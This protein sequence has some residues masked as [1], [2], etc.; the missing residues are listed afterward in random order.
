MFCFNIT[1]VSMQIFVLL[2]K[3]VG[4]MIQN[5]AGG[6]KIFRPSFRDLCFSHYI[7][8]K[9][10]CSIN[11]QYV[12]HPWQLHTC[13]DFLWPWLKKRELKIHGW[14]EW[15]HGEM[16]YQTLVIQQCCECLMFWICTL[17]QR[18][19]W[20]HISVVQFSREGYK[21][22]L[23]KSFGQKEPNSKCPGV[24]PKLSL[25]S[26]EL[27]HLVTILHVFAG[28]FDYYERKYFYSF[29]H[30]YREKSS[31]RSVNLESKFWSF[32]LN[33]EMNANI[34]VFLP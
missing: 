3:Q 32:H 15:L 25:V 21:I 33:Q 18:E 10:S 24:L 31:K 12:S 26:K 13:M 23:I 8:W 20:V 17:F 28:G 30:F 6:Q 29:N 11:G 2:R 1:I 4:F 7:T 16:I 9:I 14:N 27:N 22:K 19:K 34:F 5:F